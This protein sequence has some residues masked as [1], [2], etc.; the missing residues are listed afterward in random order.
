MPARHSI[1][2]SSLRPADMG[3][4]MLF[5]AARLKLTLADVFEPGAF[6]ARQSG[7]RVGDTLRVR[8]QDGR[9]WAEVVAIT[10][11]DTLVLEADAMTDPRELLIPPKRPATKAA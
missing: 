6:S 8:A 7:L 5:N 3:A 1:P 9:C 11:D 4:L 10:E 2:E